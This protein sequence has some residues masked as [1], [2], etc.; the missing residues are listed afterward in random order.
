MTSIKSQTNNEIWTKNESTAKS[1]VDGIPFKIVDIPMSWDM[2]DIPISN[3]IKFLKKGLCLQIL[4]ILLC[5]TTYH[6]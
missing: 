1:D 3:I 4:T 5:S 6:V 2:H